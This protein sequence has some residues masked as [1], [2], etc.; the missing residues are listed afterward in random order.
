M[1]METLKIFH[2]AK[3]TDID[4][5]LHSAFHFLDRLTLQS[6]PKFCSFTRLNATKTARYHEGHFP[7]IRV[8]TTSSILH[9]LGVIIVF[10]IICSR[11]FS[12]Y[13]T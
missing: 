11:S 5:N 2:R 12:I 13:T 10:L 4:N 1:V 9:C 7:S 3:N 6:Q 8:K